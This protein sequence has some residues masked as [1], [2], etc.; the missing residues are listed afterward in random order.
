VFDGRKEAGVYWLALAAALLGTPATSCQAPQLSPKAAA[1]LRPVLSEYLAA[2]AEEFDAAGRFV[3]ESPHTK[4]FEQRF[5]RLLAT[6]GPSADEAIAALMAFYVGEHSA[7]ELLCEAIN[8]GKRI[9][10]HLK[11]FLHCPPTTGL[12]P[13]ADFFTNIPNLRA[14]A[15]QR[16]E[17][18]EGPCA[19]E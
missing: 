5:E 10:P 3:R 1:L 4:V 8:R 19:Y 14:E 16:I 15:L 18:G 2:H 17:A 9:Q 12:E 13:I 7:E 6:S 11:R